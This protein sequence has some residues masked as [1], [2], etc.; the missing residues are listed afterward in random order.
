MDLRRKEGDTRATHSGDEEDNEDVIRI[1][2]KT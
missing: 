2:D 1:Y